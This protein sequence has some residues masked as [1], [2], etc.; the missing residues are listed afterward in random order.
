MDRSR[1]ADLE[2]IRDSVAWLGGLSDNL[3]RVGPLSIGLDGL[4][5]WIPGLG[6][7]YSAGAAAFL[8]IQG[9]RAGVPA[10]VLLS[11]AAMM[12]ART[13]VD[14]V[15]VAGALAADLFTAH[16]WSARLIVRAIDRKLGQVTPEPAVE[17][18]RSRKR[19]ARFAQQG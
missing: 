7:I 3:V 8:L 9:F 2:S 4:L 12:A 19:W 5:A 17:P 11:A 6:E 13:A 18:R 10:W 16:K 15:P 1:E 14:T